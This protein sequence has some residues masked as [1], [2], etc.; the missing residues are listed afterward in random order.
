MVIGIF[1]AFVDRQKLISSSTSSSLLQWNLLA[2]ETRKFLFRKRRE[3]FS[4]YYR[5]Q[6][7]LCIYSDVNGL[8]EELG[9]PHNS[10]EWRLFI[11]ASKLSLKLFFT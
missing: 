7:S 8:V 11:D 1:S 9:F 6:D 2:K 3:K 4:K 10:E 5:I